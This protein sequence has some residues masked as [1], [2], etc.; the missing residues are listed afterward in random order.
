MSDKINA[1]RGMNDLVGDAS[2]AYDTLVATA[3]AVLKQY[4]F[5]S[6]R[7]PLVEKTELFARSI[8][9]VTDIVEKEMYTFA[10]RNG[11]SLTLRPEG[12]AGC[13][14]AVIE[15]GLAHNQIQ[16]LYYSGPMFRHERPQKGRYRQF[17]QVGVE[18][19][20]LETVDADAELIA[21]TARLWDKLGLTGLELQIN[22]LGS[23]ESRQAYRE[24]L[25][26][27]LEQHK[28]QLDEDSLRRLNSNPLR[29]LDSKNPD[30]ADIIAGAPKLIDHLDDASKLHYQDLKAHL[31]DL[32]IE[33]TENPN[34]VR[35]LDYYNRTVFEWV[36]TEL[37]AQGTVCAGGRYDGLVEQIGGKPT[38]AVGFAMGVERLTALLMDK[39]LISI[40]PVADIYVVLAGDATKRPGLV[41]SEQIREALPHLKLQM[42]CGGGSF[43]SQ[44]KKAD[45]SG[46]K[47]ALV[48]GDNE[49]AQQQ[50]VV[51]YLRED[52]EQELIEWQSLMPHLSHIFSEAATASE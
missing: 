44:F 5:Q 34:L 43:K 28:S 32:G 25:V 13:V 3:E 7:L 12:T 16:K 19:F 21:L 9:E 11:D 22:S 42:N 18:V 49:V 37:G 46:A 17:N 52:R 36:T 23:Q 26:N 50:I 30:M 45:K 40:K 2:V 33:Y 31:D 1:I 27:Y 6:I 4:G 41:I 10:D 35:G 38:P 39:S 48:L 47:L 15:N 8:G 20:G 29:I 24:L 51:K 14:R